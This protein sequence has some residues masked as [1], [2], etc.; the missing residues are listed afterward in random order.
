MRRFYADRLR[1]LYWGNLLGAGHL[2][3]AAH[4]PD[5][6]DQLEGIVG[7]GRL[8]RLR[9]GQVVF[10]RPGQAEDQRWLE[11]FLD[12]HHMFI[13]PDGT[14]YQD[15]SLLEAINEIMRNPPAE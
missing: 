11:E 4:A 5:F 12:A 2:G 1:P 15:Q 7:A 10:W 8:S 14:E 3:A 6:L 13:H 9:T